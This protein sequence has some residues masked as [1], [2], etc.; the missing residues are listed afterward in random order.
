MVTQEWTEGERTEPYEALLYR[1]ALRAARRRAGNVW[2]G[3]VELNNVRIDLGADFSPSWS[4]SRNSERAFQR[5]LHGHMMLRDLAVML[6]KERGDRAK[7][8]GDAAVGMIRSWRREHPKGSVAVPMAWH[9]ETTALR[10]LSWIQV[11][12]ALVEGSRPVRE[13]E[14]IAEACAEQA[15][16]LLDPEFHS[17]GTNHGMFQDH[18]L[19]AWS[20][21]PVSEGRSLR[22]EAYETAK[23][24]LLSYLE[25]VIS[26]D[27]VHLEHSP[28]YHER[29]ALSMMRYEAFFSLVDDSAASSR[30]RSLLELMVPYATHVFQPDGTYPLVGD[31]FSTD[32]PNRNVFGSEE[33]RYAATGGQE[34]KAPVEVDG[35]FMSGGYAILRD[36][37]RSDGKGTYVHFAAAYHRSY[38]KHSDD[39]SV[40]LYHDGEL[41][42]ESGPNGYE[43]EDPFSRFAFGAWSHNVVLVDGEGP[44]RTE[45]ERGS[46]GL[47]WAEKGDE[48][49]RVKGVTRR[50]PGAVHER[51]VSLDRSKPSVQVVDELSGDGDC[52]FSLI[53][54]S[55]PGV[56]VVELDDGYRLERG[57]YEVATLRVDSSGGGLKSDLLWGD[58]E[59]RGGWRLGGGEPEPVWTLRFHSRG[60]YVRFTTEVELN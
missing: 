24:R 25:E 60:R 36:A 9:D 54:H 46:V 19:L 13:I 30:V 41:L 22:S 14:E 31:T 8:A 12:L 15:E 39:L 42:T 23:R 16:V 48:V 40:W 4:D 2:E 6:S 58:P 50:L 21:S 28:S 45:G 49:S 34:G 26:E 10:L 37:W 1:P 55:A 27:G 57:G 51:Q 44:A 29:V 5:L 3:W 7:Q 59:L 20:T 43:Y 53:W 32:T 33:Y 52:V 47:V 11:Y 38:H 56:A 35:I 17:S 18:A